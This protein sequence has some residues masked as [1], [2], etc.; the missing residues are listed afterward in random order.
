[1][2][3]RQ[4]RQGRDMAETRSQGDVHEVDVVIC[5]RNRDA[6]IGSAVRSVLANDHPS[7]RLTVIDQSTSDATGQ[8]L[9][10]IASTDD[11]LTYVHVDEAGLSRA[12]N[13][14]I[15][16]TSAEVLAFTD[17]DC[18]VPT[19]WISSIA[20]AF[21]AEPAG[22]LL[23]GQVVP[24]DADEWLTPLL[25]IEKAEV[26]SRS[27]GYRVFGMGANFA[28]RRRLFTSIGGFDSG[29]LTFTRMLEWFFRL[30][31]VPSRSIP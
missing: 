7:F 18:L 15:R 28:A 22:D 8:V 9:A 12:Y 1:M 14:G 5:T 25:R 19:N 16:S 23:Y 30:L 3:R 13:T 21:R 17:D 2:T 27:T 24:L 26:L 6:C 11:R 10:P 4:R 31:L 29:I 20:A